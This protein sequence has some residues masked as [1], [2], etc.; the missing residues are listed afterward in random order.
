MHYALED[1]VLDIAQNAVEAGAGLVG[2]EV[3]ETDEAVSVAITDDGVGMTEEEVA[4]ALDPFYTDGKKHA[5]RKVGLG[6]PFL[7]QAAR[8]AEGSFGIESRKGEGTRVS[9]S[10]PKG[11][12]DAPPVGDLPGLFRSILCLPG[13]HEMTIRRTRTSKSGDLSY[14]LSRKE[15]AEALGGLERGDSLAMLRDFLVSQE[16]DETD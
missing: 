2:V 13:A 3:D 6:L 10:F 5:K 14:E 11:N 9:F 12:V 1:Y 7:V 15:L 8:Q 4:R 16:E